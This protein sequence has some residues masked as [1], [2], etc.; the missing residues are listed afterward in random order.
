MAAMKRA[1]TTLLFGVTAVACLGGTPG[2]DPQDPTKIVCGCHDGQS[3]YDAAAE[4]DTRLGETGESAEELLY[5]SQCACFQDSMAGCNT[6][7]HYAKDW[8][9]ACERGEE[10]AKS[11]A[12]A[13][14]VHTHAVA[15]P[16]MSGR[17]F[18]RDPAAAHA[19][20]ARACAAGS[21]LA[22]Q[23]K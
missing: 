6:L 7:A 21:Q 14:F 1:A 8:V 20:F 17:S 3:C 5:L 10:V 23:R 4:M 9:G 13:G 22:C 18:K 12:I 2:Y 11:C 15:V 19:A 16:Q